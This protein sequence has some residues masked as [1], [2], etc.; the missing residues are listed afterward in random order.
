MNPQFIPAVRRLLLYFQ[1]TTSYP[2]LFYPIL[3]IPYNLI[4][5]KPSYNPPP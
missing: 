5:L 1:L 4:S 3:S 2:Y